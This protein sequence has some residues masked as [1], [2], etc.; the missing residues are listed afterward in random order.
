MGRRNG[1]PTT[2]LTERDAA[3]LHRMA[4]KQ[5]D[6]LMN[7]D[8]V[9]LATYQAQLVEQDMVKMLAGLALDTSGYTS[10]SLRRQCA[11]D[12]LTIAR[13][14]PKLWVHDGQTVSPSAV[15]PTGQTMGDLIEAAQTTAQLAQELDRLTREKIPP[16]EW[17]EDVRAMVGDAIT[18]FEVQN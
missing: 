14:V 13:G 7:T 1:A 2:A 3:N 11:M 6:R 4:R 17:P 16:N 18:Y 9:N 12:V 10:P 8:G 15:T 5:F